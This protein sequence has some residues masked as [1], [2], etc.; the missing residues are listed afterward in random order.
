MTLKRLNFTDTPMLR[1][2]RQIVWECDGCGGMLE[3]MTT[4]FDEAR[5]ILQENEWAYR[6]EGGEWKHYCESCR[7]PKMFRDRAVANAQR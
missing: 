1:H 7:Q 6:N 5:E 4:D 3:S 2:D